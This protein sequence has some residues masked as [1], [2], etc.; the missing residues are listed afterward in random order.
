[1]TMWVF[2]RSTG[3]SAYLLLSLSVF[4]GTLYSLRDQIK[5]VFKIPDLRIIHMYLSTMA[6][7]ATLLHGGLLLFH[8]EKERL[9]L[10]EILFPFSAPYDSFWVGIATLA[11]YLMIT[12]AITG[13]MQRR[14]KVSTWRKIHTSSYVAYVFALLHSIA[15]GTDTGS[16][17]MIVFYA[18]TGI[19]V[20]TVY[21]YR[22]IML[23][24]VTKKIPVS[25]TTKNPS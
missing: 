24:R 14:F 2:I 8:R 17:W 12:L 21:L 25:P 1:M 18:T 6:L 10:G 20:A 13:M 5:P 15:V 9:H 22:I 16:T 3:I 23:G 4:I 7:G 11:M 19:L